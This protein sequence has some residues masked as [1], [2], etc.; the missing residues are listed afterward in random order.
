MSLLSTLWNNSK[1]KKAV[2]LLL[3]LIGLS[4]LLTPFTPGSWLVFIGFKFAGIHVLFWD[5]I[6]LWFDKHDSK[7]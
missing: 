4:A 3:I 1:V 7:K 2:G 5:K 6:K